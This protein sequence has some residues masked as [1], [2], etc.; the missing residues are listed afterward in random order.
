MGD[1]VFPFWGIRSLRTRRAFPAWARV[2]TRIFP[3]VP[4]P[5]SRVGTPALSLFH[6][7]RVRRCPIPARPPSRARM[8]RASP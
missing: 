3:G 7:S 2:G 8:S 5:L 4:N 1:K 6:P